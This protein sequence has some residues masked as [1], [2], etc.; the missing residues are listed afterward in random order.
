MERELIEKRKQIERDYFAR[1]IDE[2][3]FNRLLLENYDRL[4]KVRAK[5]K[6]LSQNKK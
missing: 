3:Y 1:K 5:L 4:S 6:E 2:S